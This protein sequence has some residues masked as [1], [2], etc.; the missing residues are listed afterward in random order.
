MFIRKTHIRNRANQKSYW[1]FQLVESIR[2]ERGPRQRILLNLGVDLDLND[3][4]RKEL[5]NRI[6][7]ILTGT[8]SIFPSSKNRKIRSKFFFTDFR[9]FIFFYNY[10]YI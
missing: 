10:F 2:T 3:L 9:S 4:E 8:L 1:N 6:E 5:A 7:E